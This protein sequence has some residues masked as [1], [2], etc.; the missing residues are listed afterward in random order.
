MA[1][2]RPSIFRSRVDLSVV[3]LELHAG[4][5]LVRAVL[6]AEYFA[7]DRIPGVRDLGVVPGAV[8]H[9]LG[10]AQRVA[11]M[12][13]GDFRGELRQ[14]R[15]LLDGRIPSADDRDFFPS[16]K[17]AVAGSTCAD[18]IAPV[19]TFDA[20]P[21]RRGAGSHDQRIARVFADRSARGIPA[22]VVSCFDS[23]RPAR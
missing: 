2:K 1:R 3:D 12:D 9:D 15:G 19:W 17:V 21:S 6:F 4:Q 10:G 18:A 14:E 13:Q 5:Y 16:I 7:D 8:L 11:A 20:Q 22:G 23:E